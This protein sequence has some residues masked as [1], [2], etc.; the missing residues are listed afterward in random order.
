MPVIKTKKALQEM[1]EN[2][3]ITV[4]VDNIEAIENIEKMVKDYTG[5]TYTTGESGENFTITITKGS[6][7][8][9][10]NAKKESGSVVII[11][12][13]KMGKGSDE[14]GETLLK[15]FIYSLTESDVLPNAIIFYNDGVKSTT[16][17]SAS[18]ESLANLSEMGVDILSCG[19]CLQYHDLTKSLEVGRVSNMYEISEILLNATNVIT[20]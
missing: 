16:S 11:S 8:L 9:E 5:C 2:G 14:L 10:S 4:L 3:A 13:D 18:I 17:G 19:A 20:I 12:S 6:G 7:G 1:G 15:M